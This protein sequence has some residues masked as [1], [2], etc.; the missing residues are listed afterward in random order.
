[1]RKLEK[2]TKLKIS[3]ANDAEAQ[4]Q[5]QVEENDN[6][7][8]QRLKEETPAPNTFGSFTMEAADFEKVCCLINIL[9]LEN[10]LGIQSSYF[11]YSVWRCFNYNILR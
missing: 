1:M 10:S 3:A 4:A 9:E 5:N 11:K 8:V 7:K 6:E 2:L